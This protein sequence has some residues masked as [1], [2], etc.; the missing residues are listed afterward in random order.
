MQRDTDFTLQD[1][2]YS[3]LGGSSFQLEDLGDPS[4]VYSDLR[5][6]EVSTSQEGC[7]RDAEII[8]T[9]TERGEHRN[10]LNY[11]AVSYCWDSFAQ[12]TSD[13][14]S[15]TRVLVQEC[16]QG[17][18]RLPKCPSVVL[19]RAISFARSNDV[20]MIWIDQECDNQADPIDV[21]NHLQCNHISFQQAEHTIGLLNFQLINLRQYGTLALLNRI[22]RGQLH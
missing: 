13:A 20:S 5:F 4:P 3:G 9:L 2:F 15:S 1:I 10:E 22:Y 7:S 12:G 14:A 19:L 8:C 6:L 21:Q 11:V 17:V 16:N 18:P